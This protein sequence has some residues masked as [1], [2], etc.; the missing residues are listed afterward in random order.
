MNPYFQLTTLQVISD[1]ESLL[2]LNIEK[3]YY[4]PGDQARI[5]DVPN[6]SS[7]PH[8]TAGI[9][10]GQQKDWPLI[11]VAFRQI[12]NQG[13]DATDPEKIVRWIQATREFRRVSR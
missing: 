1:I 2:A 8:S 6:G 3:T 10:R 11:P 9:F 5:A 12:E 7:I 13:A 4:F